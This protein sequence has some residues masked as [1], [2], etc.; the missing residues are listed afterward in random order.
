MAATEGVMDLA[1]LSGRKVA[2]MDDL[3]PRLAQIL[4]RGNIDDLIALGRPPWP[5]IEGVAKVEIQALPISRTTIRVEGCEVNSPHA[6]R[7]D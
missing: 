4:V 7:L 6:A 5:R 2:K 3:P 1:I